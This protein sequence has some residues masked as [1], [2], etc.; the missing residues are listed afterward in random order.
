MLRRASWPFD[1][2][3]LVCC[4]FVFLTMGA[5]ALYPGGTALDSHATSYHFFENFFSDLGRTI[6]RGSNKPNPFG[7]ALFFLALTSA[8]VALGVF[9]VAFAR[10]FW[11][12][13]AQRVFTTA[14]VLFGLVSAFNFLGIALFRANLSPTK[15][16]QFVF[17]AFKTFPLAV[18][19]F[20]IAMFLGGSYP[21]RG[22]WIFI[23]FFGILLAYLRLITA[24][25]PPDSASGLM[26]QATG[27]KAVVYASLLCVGAQA[28]VAR[29]H[30]SHLN[31]RQQ[32]KDAS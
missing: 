7:S 1:F 32:L 3:I 15:H 28:I 24:G 13:L 20:G 17:A 8:G 29:R 23:A 6:A 2:V 9:F 10:F 11:N 19:F 14:G 25:P 4:A 5:M 27:Q 30:L 26:I 12:G 16:V 22:A 31:A 18:L 21:K